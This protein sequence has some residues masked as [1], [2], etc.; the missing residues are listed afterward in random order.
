MNQ[1]SFKKSI[2]FWKKGMN[3]NFKTMNSLY[4]SKRYSACLFFGHL[5]LEKALKILVMERTR[6]YASRTHN[7]HRLAEAS[8]LKLEL[9]ELD[10]LAIANAF[11]MEGR[12]PEEKFDFYK[13][14]N[15][16]YTDKFFPKIKKTHKR[17]CQLM[18]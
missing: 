14:C 7:L 3:D 16:S 18:K 1:A 6:E 5:V 11:N 15:K 12:Y 13:L 9:R 10:F 4:K 8:G 2:A 17:L